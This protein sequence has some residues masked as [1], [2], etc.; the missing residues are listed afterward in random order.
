MPKISLGLQGGVF[1]AVLGLVGAG[2]P[3]VF[4]TTAAWVGY[5]LIVS[6]IVLALWGVR[7]DDQHWWRWR[8]NIP[9]M[10]G[11]TM[12]SVV[13]LAYAAT[14]ERKYIFRSNDK[15]GLSLAFY[16]SASETFTLVVTDRSSETYAVQIPF[17][18]SGVPFAQMINLSLA[19]GLEHGRTILRVC[20]NGRVVALRAFPFQIGLPQAPWVLIIGE[21]LSNGQFTE[22]HDG[23][24]FDLYEFAAFGQFLG[25]KEDKAAARAMMQNWQV[26]N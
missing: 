1:S 10:A 11:Y 2:V 13:K 23:A 25:T 14:S 18:S 16:L 20:V 8:S 12:H 21:S 26:T 22:I 17:N 9:S 3:A 24:G 7:I 19:L 4:P 6:G 5:V 15:S